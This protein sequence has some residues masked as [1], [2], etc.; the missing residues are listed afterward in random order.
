[1]SIRLRVSWPSDI[2]RNI[3]ETPQALNDWLD[4]C[5]WAETTEIIVAGYYHDI[6][7]ESEEWVTLLHL[8]Y[9]NLKFVRQL[10][11]HIVRQ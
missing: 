7:V 8:K 1:M 5:A 2:L 10:L 3:V 4:Y 6:T 11:P 9:P